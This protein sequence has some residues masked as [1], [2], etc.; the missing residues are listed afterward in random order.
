MIKRLRLK[1]VATNM[2]IVT[3]LLCVILGLVY[4]FTS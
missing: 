3:I 1:F 4:Y 2:I